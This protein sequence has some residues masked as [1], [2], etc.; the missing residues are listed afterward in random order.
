MFN[1]LVKFNA[2]AQPAD[3]MYGGRILEYT[4]D[5]LI[6]RFK[7]GG[8]LDLPA[9]I[10]LPTLLAQESYGSENPVARVGTILRAYPNGRDISVEYVYDPEIPPIPNATLETYAAELGIS[11]G[12]FSRTHW[13]VKDF[14]LFRTLLRHQQ[15]RRVRPRV[16]QIADPEAVEPTLVSVMMP[17]RLSSTRSTNQS[18]NQSLL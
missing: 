2:W 8:Q 9:L 7:P 18:K 11:P 17:L 4:D 15:P 5:A 13:S 1:F 6:A 14:D 3:S 12:Q 10:A 16:F